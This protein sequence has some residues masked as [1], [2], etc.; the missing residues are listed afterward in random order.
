MIRWFKRKKK[1]DQGEVRKDIRETDIEQEEGPQDEE[2]LVDE[3][4]VE[5]RTPGPGAEE[6]PESETLP[7]EAAE[8]EETRAEEETWAEEEEDT[9][10]EEEEDQESG[11]Q[12]ESAPKRGFFRRLRQRLKERGRNSSAG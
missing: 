7:P 6:E 2:V 1:K 3:T 8:E 4:G 5:I 12:E 10:E 11:V 9:W